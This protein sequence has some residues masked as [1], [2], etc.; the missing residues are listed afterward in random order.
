[1]DLGLGHWALIRHRRRG[2][3]KKILGSKNNM[4][5]DLRTRRGVSCLENGLERREWLDTGVSSDWKES[6]RPNAKPCL[7]HANALELYF[8]VNKEPTS[9]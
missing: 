4:N 2:G 8:V 3:E 1:M 7:Y 9:V 6:T 5:S